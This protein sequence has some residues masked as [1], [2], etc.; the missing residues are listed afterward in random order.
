MTQNKRNLNLLQTPPL[1]V[2][3]I[4]HNRAKSSPPQLTEQQFSGSSEACG[5]VAT[6]LIVEDN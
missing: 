3:I 4:G 6:V 5:C 2:A 1:P